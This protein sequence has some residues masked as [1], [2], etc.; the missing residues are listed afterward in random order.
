MS[1]LLLSLNMSRFTTINNTVTVLPPSS[2]TYPPSNL[3]LLSH[4]YFLIS[5]MFNFSFFHVPKGISEAASMIYLASLGF[6][7]TLFDGLV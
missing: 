2:S 5:Y 7:I 3:S 4:H 1:T 6:G